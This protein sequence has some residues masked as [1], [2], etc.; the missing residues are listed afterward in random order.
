M[1]RVHERLGLRAEHLRFR[2]GRQERLRGGAQR[3]R[4]GALVGVADGRCRDPDVPVG[5]RHGQ[6][7]VWRLQRGREG[8]RDRLALRRPGGL[9]GASDERRRRV[10][11]FRAD[12]RQPDGHRRLRRR[13]QGRHGCLPP[14]RERRGPV[15]LVVQAQQRLRAHSGRLGREPG[16]PDP[17]RLRRGPEGRLHHPAQCRRR[18]VLLAPGL[19]GR[20]RQ[21]LPVGAR[22]GLRRSVGLQRRRASGHDGEPEQR[23]RRQLVRPQRRHGDAPG[24]PGLASLGRHR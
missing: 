16:L 19:P 21:R 13:P 3:G 15:D 9:L 17:R 12:G 23:R 10:R 5:S 7:R 2:W 18:G 1:A 24:G 20:R 14:G 4:P 22:L 6:S 8:R 11:A